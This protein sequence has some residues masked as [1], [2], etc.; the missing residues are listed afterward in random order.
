MRFDN[1]VALVTGGHSGIGL[2]TAKCLA[3]EGATVVVTVVEDAQRDGV[4]DFDAVTLDVR[5]AD[6]WDRVRTHLESQY[7]GLDVLINNAGINRRGGLQE[8]TYELWSEIMNVN[9]WGTVLGC[10]KM[11]PLMRKSGGGAIVNLS[12]VAALSGPANLL[13]YSASKGA[14]KTL[15]TALATEHASENVRINCVCPG[16]VK[17]PML[18]EIIDEAPDPAALEEVIVARH[19]IGRAATA[20]EI[21]SV[22]AFLASDDASFMT[23]I[24]VPVDGGRSIR[25]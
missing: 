5:S 20:D 6:M 25:F 4:S 21:A 2:A 24:A 12:S 10:Q 8:T 15:T 23:G 16:A 14:I 1:K 9:A 3:N 11:I 18:D 13:A 19:P 17:T 22:I 7:G